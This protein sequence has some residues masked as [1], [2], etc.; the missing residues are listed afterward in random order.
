MVWT[1]TWKDTEIDVDTHA[2]AYIDVLQTHTS[3]HRENDL[4]TSSFIGAANATPRR[5]RRVKIGTALGRPRPR[6]CSSL[7]HCLVLVL[8]DV[9]VTRAQP[10]LAIGGGGATS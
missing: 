6:T 4:A 1:W 5:R 10:N 2:D 8:L 7:R 9:F 3:K